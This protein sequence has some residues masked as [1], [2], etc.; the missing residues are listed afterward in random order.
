[1]IHPVLI[2]LVVFFAW[3]IF[4]KID[5]KGIKFILLILAAYVLYTVPSPVKNI[6]IPPLK[7][8]AILSSGEEESDQIGFYNVNDF[9]LEILKENF[10]EGAEITEYP[11][12]TLAYEAL[13]DESI[14]RLVIDE[15][16]MDDSYELTL[17]KRVTP[18]LVDGV[19][20]DPSKEPSLIYVTGL[21]SSDEA[22]MKSRSDMNLLVAINPNTHK[23]TMASLARDTYL[24][25]AC[26]DNKMDKLTHSGL[27]GIQCQ[28]DSIENLTGLEIDLYARTHFKGFEALVDAL[29]GID[30]SVDESFGEFE[31]GIESMDG[32]TALRFV[33]SR[34]DLSNGD[35]GRGENGQ[36]VLE[37]II[38][39]V[40]SEDFDPVEVMSLFELVDTNVNAF[41]LVR[42]VNQKDRYDIERLVLEGKGDMQETYS[43]NDGYKY[44]VFWPDQ[45][46]LNDIT[47]SLQET[48]RGE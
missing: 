6:T 43:Q 26:Q 38:E 4:K 39:K 19:V 45:E 3:R 44:Y 20:K 30:V 14:S 29:G 13:L 36:R 9:H 25:L 2:L 28:I 32:S 18:N 48:L 34:Y 24:P 27:Y 33:R 11:S 35:I 16:E 47:S 8:Y 42:L 1:M 41:D 10:S 5:K 22:L 31:A 15:S 23:I 7:T 46:S 40:V 17:V 21:D 12:K 37:A